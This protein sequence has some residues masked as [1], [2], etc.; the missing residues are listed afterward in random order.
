MDVAR[1]LARVGSDV[2]ADLLCVAGSWVRIVVEGCIGVRVGG[3]GVHVLDW[4]LIKLA[5][6]G[7]GAA[8]VLAAW[9]GDRDI[10]NASDDA[11]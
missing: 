7:I 5:T 3:Q 9:G 8:G 2:V 6:I 1:G 4:S 10:H 11:R